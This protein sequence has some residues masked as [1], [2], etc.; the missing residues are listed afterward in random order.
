MIIE[1]KDKNLDYRH[2]LFILE[3]MPK[4]GICAEVGVCEG[5]YTQHI[6][7]ITK[8][9]KLYLIE[10]YPSPLFY[11]TC[12]YFE[13]C[14]YEFHIK[15]FE[16]TKFPNNYFDWIYL[17]DGH[18]LEESIAQIKLA[19]KLVKKGGYI[20]GDDY[21]EEQLSQKVAVDFFVKKNNVEWFE[22]IN[23]QFK[24]RKL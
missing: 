19:Y 13:K 10:P 18:K 12:K 3:E 5:T 22:P 11:K 21:R 8:P 16:N 7:R 20:I 4:N 15:K 1:P 14:D 9:K 2:R 23:W 17:D 6:I 24:I